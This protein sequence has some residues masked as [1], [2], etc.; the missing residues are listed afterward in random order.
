MRSAMKK[1]IIIKPT[2]SANEG[3]FMYVTREI[4]NDFP[5]HGNLGEFYT[6]DSRSLEGDLG[7]SLADDIIDLTDEIYDKLNGKAY[8]VTITLEEVPDEELFAPVPTEPLNMSR[9]E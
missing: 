4:F 7:Q 5:V 9:G 3:L 6:Q 1:T 8:R 2:K